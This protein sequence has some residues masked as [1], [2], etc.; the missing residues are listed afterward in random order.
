MMRKEDVDGFARARPFQPFEIQLVDGQ[1][2]RLTSV[3]QFII[4]RS[5]MS[6]LTPKGVL[7]YIGIGLISTIRPL[8]VAK[9]RRPRK[10]A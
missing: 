6:V 8:R 9:A 10:R 2:F 1:R 5:A 7:V 3:E 4:G